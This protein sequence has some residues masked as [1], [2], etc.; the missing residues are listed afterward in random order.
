[1][2][3][4]IYEPNYDPEYDMQVEAA[5]EYL[6]GGNINEPYNVLMKQVAKEQT[7]AAKSAKDLDVYL[8][9]GRDKSSSWLKKRKEK[10]GKKVRG[11]LEYFSVYERD[12]GEIDNYEEGV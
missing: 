4:L 2:E 1:M 8:S 10:R 3:F 9:K 12:I 5:F 11:V 6:L 7:M